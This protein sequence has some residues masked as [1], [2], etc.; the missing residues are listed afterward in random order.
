MAQSWGPTSAL[1]ITVPFLETHY[2]LPRLHDCRNLPRRMQFERSRTGKRDRAWALKGLSGA[3]F[4]PTRKIL[5]RGLEF[6]AR[7]MPE[8]ARGGPRIRRETFR[9]PFWGLFLDA[10][11]AFLGASF[12]STRKILPRGLDFAARLYVWPLFPACLCARPASLPVLRPRPAAAGHRPIRPVFLSPFPA[13]LRR[14][15]PW[16]VPLCI[17]WRPRPAM[18]PPWA[19]RQ[20][21][22]REPQA[23]L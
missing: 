11:E 13:Q 10:V 8:A 12:Q 1:S 20:T 6:S 16:K 23:H 19:A 22:R 2:S 14:E 5:T 15:R 21:N 17:L 4:Q 7:D 18:P 3:S 9:G